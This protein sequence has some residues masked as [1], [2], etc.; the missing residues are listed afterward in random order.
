MGGSFAA[1][2]SASADAA[3]A[4]TASIT[5]FNALDIGFLGF[6]GPR[7]LRIDKI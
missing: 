6:N 7:I 1:S 2:I 5:F 4:P 3:A